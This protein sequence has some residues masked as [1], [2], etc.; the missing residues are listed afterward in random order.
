MDAMLYSL[1]PELE[2]SNKTLVDTGDFDIRAL[3]LP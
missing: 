2:F 3:A 1:K